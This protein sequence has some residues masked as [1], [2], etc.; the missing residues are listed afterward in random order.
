MKV[1]V[2]VT[3]SKERVGE[4]KQFLEGFFVRL[5]SSEGILT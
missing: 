5:S 1:R 4:I 3:G 2:T